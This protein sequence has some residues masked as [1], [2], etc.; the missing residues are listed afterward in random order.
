[1]PTGRGRRAHVPGGVQIF[2][3]AL[4]RSAS[5]VGRLVLA[6]RATRSCARRRSVR[7]RPAARLPRIRHL[8]LRQRVPDRRR[9]PPPGSSGSSARTASIPSLRL[10]EVLLL[11]VRQAELARRQVHQR[12]H[13]LEQHVLHRDAAHLRLERRAQ[14]L[15]G[16]A[17]AAARSCDHPLA[18]VA[19][20]A[21]PPPPPVD[22]LDRRARLERPPLALGAVLRRQRHVDAERRRAPAR[23]RPAAGRRSPPPGTPRRRSRSIMRAVEP[24]ADRPPEVL[25]D[26]PAGGRLGRARPRRTRAPPGPRRRR[27]GPPARSTPRPW[28][29]RRRCAPPRCRTRDAAGRST[30]AAC[31]RRSSS[32]RTR[33][34][35]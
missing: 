10:V 29:A 19:C 28:T 17:P 30:R 21:W 9:P 13:R 22:L 7:L 27:S 6:A 1:M 32:S 31:A 11:A 2:A 3:R 14:L 24:V 34:S 20:A 25:L 5:S 16:A 8:E 33:K 23:S 15:L 18:C 12:H 35:T 4:A 26:Q